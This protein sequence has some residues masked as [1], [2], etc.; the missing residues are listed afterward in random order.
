MVQK[1]NKIGDVNQ[2]GGCNEI[3][4]TAK[5]PVATYNVVPLIATYDMGVGV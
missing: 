4:Q 5:M 1:C 2:G 3:F